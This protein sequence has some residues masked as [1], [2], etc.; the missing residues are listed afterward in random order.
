M[1]HVLLFHHVQGLT[2]GL[3]AFAERLREG[4]HDVTLPDLFA[5]HTFGT[6]EEGMAFRDQIGHDRLLE[7]AA[8]HVEEL[9]TGLVYGGFSMGIVPAMSFIQRR[10]G[11]LGALFYSGIVPLGYFGDEWPTK[12]PLQIHLMRGD[13]FEDESDAR[14]LAAAAGGELFMYDA[15]GHLF[16]DSSSDAYDAAATEEVLRRSLELLATV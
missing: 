11:A 16:M 7:R 13:P 1:A 4:G 8:A 15:P 14:E 2:A 10:P 9:P 12:V 6:I 3:E 5:G